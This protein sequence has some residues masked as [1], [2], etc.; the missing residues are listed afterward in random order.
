MRIEVLLAVSVLAV[1]V[2]CSGG[3]KS[4]SA[5]TGAN[6]EPI[7]SAPALEQ[8]GPAADKAAAKA[9]PEAPKA[10]IPKGTKLSVRIDEPLSTRRNRAGDRFRA[11]LASPLVVEGKTVVPAGAAF[12]GNVTGSD[13]SG[14]LKGRAVLS[15]TLAAF[16][17]D[18]KE[19]AVSTNEVVRQSDSHKKRN[20]GFIAGGSGLGA[21][22]G[23]IAG[24]GKGALIG[25]AAGAGAGTAG[26]AAT[27]KLQV[28]LPV[29]TALTFS[30]KTPVTLN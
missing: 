25:A 29:E 11:T 6:P 1:G 26:A 13:E 7:A 21:A 23:A 17:V 27:G 19:F 15:L 24:G 18:G 30:L 14:R 22:I 10:V 5:A 9:E 12:T 4:P 8:P 2:G 28:N 20:V 16:T 3:G